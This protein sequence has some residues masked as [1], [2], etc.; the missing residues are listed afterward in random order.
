[1]EGSKRYGQRGRRTDGGCS[2]M[3]LAD[4]EAQLARDGAFSSLRDALAGGLR[5]PSPS[6]AFGAADI[7]AEIDSIL[8]D[9]E[10]LAAERPDPDFRLAL[11]ANVIAS[12][13]DLGRPA[14]RPTVGV[15]ELAG[16]ITSGWLL[17]LAGAGDPGRN[18]ISGVARARAAVADTEGRTQLGR[19]LRELVQAAAGGQLTEEQ[20]LSRLNAASPPP[21][22][23]DAEGP[24]G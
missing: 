4:L 16:L 9:L 20:F 22:C 11:A 21:G 6:E 10:K 15:G 2:G 13:H 17:V 18:F 8:S 12:L 19:E 7:L 24:A 1:M 3:T 14:D 5:W 23:V